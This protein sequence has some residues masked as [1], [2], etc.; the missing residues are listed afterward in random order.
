VFVEQR[1]AALARR[2]DVELEVV[3]PA[4][5]FPVVGWMRAAGGPAK[6]LW[7]GLTVHRPRFV[8]IPKVFKSLDGRL[9]ARSLQQWFE[10]F[11]AEWRP[12]LLDAHF[13]WPDGV[14]VAL[15]AQRL[16]LPYA[17][18]L[19]GWLYEAMQRPRILRQCV[20]AMRG[21][22]V[23]ISVEPGMAKLACEL[24]VEPERVRV[25]PNG[26]DM[27]RFCPSD[28]A[29]ARR[30]LGLP[31]DGRLLVSVGHLGRRK[32]HFETLEALRRLPDDVRLLLVGGDA[33]DGREAL[34]LRRFAE[35]LGVGDRVLLAGRQPHGRMPL[36]Y[37]AADASVLASW[38]EG[39]PNVVL[40]SLASGRPV[41][42]TNVGSVPM[43]IRDGQNGR[44]VPPRDVGELGSAVGDLLN[45]L[46]SPDQ[47]R[48]SPAVR[49]WDDV[50][51]DVVGTLQSV[52]RGPSNNGVQASPSEELLPQRVS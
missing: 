14:G 1:L 30:E 7:N 52:V 47:V 8:C 46:P 28:R 42:A 48:Q 10:R 35:E 15:L 3:S 18:T 25:I 2:E 39:C 13:V 31:V 38:R 11:A 24:G 36:Y 40:E 45:D 49:S 6:E 26:V 16:G 27:E 33:P 34:A 19:R 21:A 43:M 17:I 22:A 20:P 51:D 4:A 12:D 9:Y 41:V 37:A 50:A 29:A 32:G 44:I 23:V 5:W